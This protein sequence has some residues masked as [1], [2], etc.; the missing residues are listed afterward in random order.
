VRED[1]WDE[2]QPEITKYEPPDALV[3]GPDGLGA[4]RELVAGAAPGTRLALEHAPAQ[5]ADV[6]ALLR[7]ARTLADLAGRERVTV[8]SAP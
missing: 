8:G 5:A 2:L 7:D 6:R 4:I 1:E 3:A